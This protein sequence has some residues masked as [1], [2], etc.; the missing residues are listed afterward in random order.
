MTQF[1][2]KTHRAKDRLDK[3]GGGYAWAWAVADLTRTRKVKDW[4][5][6]IFVPTSPFTMDAAMTL[7]KFAPPEH[8]Q[9]LIDQGAEYWGQMIAAMITF[10]SWRMTQG[11]YRIDPAVYRALADTPIDGDI[12]VSVLQQMPEWCIYI[13]TPAAKMVDDTPL[14][15]VWVRHDISSTN[16]PTLAITLD[17]ESTDSGMPPS[18]HLIF[19]GGSLAD[20]I[21]AARAAWVQNGGAELPKNTDVDRVLPWVSLV[22]NL[23][24]YICCSGY[25]IHGKRGQPGNPEPKRTRRDGWRLFPADGVRTWDVGVRMGAALRAAYHAEETGQGGQH[26]GVR[27]HIRR[28]HWHG[29]RSGKRINEDGTPIPAEKRPYHLKWLPP[30]AVN[31]DGVDNLPATIRRVP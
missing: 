12:P 29:F 15:G 20:A 1:Q 14:H 21:A 19:D 22:V 25:D 23:L 13:E 10:A 27:G 18:Q 8:V 5:E 9:W 28:A 26:G 31:L 2:K 3:I 24:L 7:R 30:I 17:V 11:I 16:L 6:H 4:P